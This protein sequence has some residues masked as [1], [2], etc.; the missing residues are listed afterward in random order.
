[1]TA[2]KVRPT[3]LISSS[4]FH[5]DSVIAATVRLSISWL[6]RDP[7]PTHLLTRIGDDD[8]SPWAA[9]KSDTYDEAAGACHGG[10]TAEC[11]ALVAVY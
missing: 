10:V 9:D 2:L 4:G 1:M 3:T 7:Q 5:G 8:G 11:E 6:A